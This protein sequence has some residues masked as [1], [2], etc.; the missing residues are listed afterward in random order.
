MLETTV[1]EDIQ[2]STETLPEV[3]MQ[4][5]VNLAETVLVGC[6]YGDVELRHWDQGR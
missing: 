4:G 6:V 2:A 5:P 1:A 3:S